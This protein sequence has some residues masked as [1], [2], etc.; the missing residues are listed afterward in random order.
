M[1][2]ILI[3]QHSLSLPILY[4]CSKLE[5]HFGSIFRVKIAVNNNLQFASSLEA[6]AHFSRSKEKTLLNII[7]GY[8]MA[9]TAQKVKTFLVAINWLRAKLVSN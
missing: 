3:N 8:C 4:N 2:I 1:D 9:F 7:P 6:T 5:H